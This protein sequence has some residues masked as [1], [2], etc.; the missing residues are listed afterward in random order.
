MQE[1][2]YV[3]PYEITD[4]IIHLIAEISEQVGVVTMKVSPQ[5]AAR[6]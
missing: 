6:Y 5:Q 3:P 2:S 4:A 1:K